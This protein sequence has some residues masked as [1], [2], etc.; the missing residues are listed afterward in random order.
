MVTCPLLPF[1]FGKCQC[2]GGSK[3]REIPMSWF[4]TPGALASSPTPWMK[5]V[6]WYFM[7]LVLITSVL[8]FFSRVAHSPARPFSASRVSSFSLTH[9]HLLME[10]P[11]PPPAVPTFRPIHQRTRLKTRKRAFFRMVGSILSRSFF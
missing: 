3:K 4:L 1:V 7:I 8:A 5:S 10:T 2:L 9:F 11:F 6:F